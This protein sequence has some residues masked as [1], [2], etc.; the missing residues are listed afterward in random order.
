ML[1]SNSER[2][3]K[4]EKHLEAWVWAGALVVGWFST[5]GSLQSDLAFLL[6]SRCPEVFP[7]I[8][9]SALGV[10]LLTVWVWGFG[11]RTDSQIAL[12]VTPIAKSTAMNFRSLSFLSSPLV[13]LVTRNSGLCL[14]RFGKGQSP[15]EKRV[16][17]SSAP[18]GF[19]FQSL[20]WVQVKLVNVLLL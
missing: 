15:K 1:E 10:G 4:E 18:K 6:L 9:G 16:W 20:L 3:W 12:T 7:S 17:D 14:E 2:K 13:V 11:R 8:P 5:S 19:A